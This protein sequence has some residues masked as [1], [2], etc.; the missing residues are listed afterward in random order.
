MANKQ[1]HTENEAEESEERWLLTYSDMIT[2]LLALF[3]ILYSISTVDSKKFAEIAEKF[4]ELLDNPA[5]HVTISDDVGGPGAVGSSDLELPAG[6]V[7]VDALDEVY[8]I[9]EEYVEANH[10]EGQIS[11]ENTSTFVKI[12]LKDT[13]MFHP[14]SPELLRSSEPILREINDALRQVYDRV[15]SITIGGHTADIGLHSIESDQ[16]AWKLSTERAITVLNQFVGYGLPQEKLTIEGRGR[17]SPI[18]SN[19]TKEGMA[20]NRRVEITIIKADVSSSGMTDTSSSS[21]ASSE[22]E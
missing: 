19:Q 16:I 12:H 14:D 21:M 1:K 6:G 15:D 8:D 9:L 2:L 3:I 4:G 22:A 13:L 18:A 20:K 10:L 7:P 17:F 11:L 5:A